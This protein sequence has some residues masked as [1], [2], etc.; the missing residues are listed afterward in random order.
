MARA[1]GAGQIA[2]ETFGAA[3]PRMQHVQYDGFVIESRIRCRHRLLQRGRD[4]LAQIA[5]RGWMRCVFAGPR[6]FRSVQYDA[7]I[8]DVQIRD[9]HR[10]PRRE[11]R[12]KGRATQRFEIERAQRVSVPRADQVRYRRPCDRLMAATVIARRIDAIAGRIGRRARRQRRAFGFAVVERRRDEHV[13]E[14]QRGEQARQPEFRQ[15]GACA[16]QDDV[17]TRIFVRGMAQRFERCRCC[18]MLDRRE[19]CVRAQR[20]EPRRVRLR[21]AENAGAGRHGAVSFHDAAQRF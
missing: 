6:G 2:H 1:I 18:R 8:G 17:V 5:E 13:R 3:A 7:R 4:T 10:A 21:R 20:I 9:E 11:L 12:G 16:N 15:R 14:I 19:R